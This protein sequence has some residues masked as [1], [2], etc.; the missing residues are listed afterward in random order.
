MTQNGPRDFFDLVFEALA[1]IQTL[2]RLDA[3]LFK[4]EIKASFKNLLIS[5]AIALG[6]VALL[7]FGLAFLVDSLFLL[8]VAFGVAPAVAALSLAFVCIA[9]SALLSWLVIERFQ[10]STFTPKRTWA[11]IN[12]NLATFKAG[13]SNVPPTT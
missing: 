13:F 12:Q 4:A 6:A 10:R 2:A 8:L 11:Q 9:I 5:C 1:D 7:F 3:L